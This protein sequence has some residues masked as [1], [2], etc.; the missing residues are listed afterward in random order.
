MVAQVAKYNGLCFAWHDTE[1]RWW[2]VLS[3]HLSS[4]Q[5][6]VLPVMVLFLLATTG[7]LFPC[8][9]G[10]MAPLQELVS[11]MFG[12]LLLLLPEQMRL[13]RVIG[14]WSL[15]ITVSFFSHQGKGMSGKKVS[16]MAAC[17]R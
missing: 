2:E 3:L 4:V 1:E 8:G 7:H 5:A 16:V 12:P 10:C 15:M 13:S 6:P 9:L 17:R 14:S 11:H